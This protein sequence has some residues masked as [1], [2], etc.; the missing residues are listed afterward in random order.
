MD[1]LKTIG[2][3]PPTG[4]ALVS[5]RV[6]V[7]YTRPFFGLSRP[8]VRDHQFLVVEDVR[9]VRVFAGSPMTAVEYSWN[10]VDLTGSW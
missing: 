3:R 2:L 9:V 10:G 4:V 6:Q 7:T 8:R 1:W 5:N